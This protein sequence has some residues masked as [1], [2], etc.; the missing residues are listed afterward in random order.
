MP[1]GCTP[2]TRGSDRVCLFF[3]GY[4][5]A[6]S[7]KPPAFRNSPGIL[8]RLCLPQGS[9]CLLSLINQLNRGGI[10]SRVSN[11]FRKAGGFPPCAAA[12]PHN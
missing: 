9:A 3:C 2:T 4:A 1:G 6:H 10:A 11:T 12:K 5:A 7:G 8:A